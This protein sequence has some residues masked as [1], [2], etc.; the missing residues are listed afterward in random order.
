M[1]EAGRKKTEELARRTK[2]LDSSSAGKKK[3]EEAARR[4]KKLEGALGKSRW[5]EDE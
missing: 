2:E 4:T 3:T 5:A 1:S